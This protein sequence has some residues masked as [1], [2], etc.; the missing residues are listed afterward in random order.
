[1]YLEKPIESNSPKPSPNQ[2][3]V[4]FRSSREA[5]EYA[6]K[7][8]INGKILEAPPIPAGM[9]PVQFKSSEE[10][11]RFMQKQSASMGLP[12]MKA[13][14]S[15]SMTP[16]EAE[17]KRKELMKADLEKLKAVPQKNY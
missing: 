7:H 6:K 4:Q 14:P 1:M 9:K 12:L 8:P 11:L 15:P 5:I 2:G 17:K 13:P 16:E 3:V 10:A